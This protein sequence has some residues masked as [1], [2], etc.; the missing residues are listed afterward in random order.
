M[1][2][3]KLRNLA[4]LKPNLNFSRQGSV[5]F[6]YFCLKR[7]TWADSILLVKYIYRFE[8]SVSC[9]YQCEIPLSFEVECLQD[10]EQN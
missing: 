6:C 8:I 1:I 5:E 9:F 2:L 7:L 3:M 4:F 10:I